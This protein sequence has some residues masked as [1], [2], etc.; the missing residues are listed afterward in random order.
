MAISCRPG[1]QRALSAPPQGRSSVQRVATRRPRP[2][3][4]ARSGGTPSR[5][6][7]ADSGAGLRLKEHAG[8]SLRAKGADFGAVRRGELRGHGRSFPFPIGLGGSPRPRAAAMRNGVSS[9]TR[10]TPAINGQSALAEVRGRGSGKLGKNSSLADAG[11]SRPSV[12]RRSARPSPARV[13]SKARAASRSA[14]SK[15]SVKDA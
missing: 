5:R 10:G 7:P 15:P 9:F 13:S 14:A 11:G 3:R 8:R 12:S 1:A 6:S 2:R 4:P